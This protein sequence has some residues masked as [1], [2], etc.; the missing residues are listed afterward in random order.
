M[1]PILLSHTGSRAILHHWRPSGPW[2]AK[3]I[4]RGRDRAST[5]LRSLLSRAR[6]ELGDDRRAGLA[7]CEPLRGRWPDLGGRPL[8]AKGE[9]EACLLLAHGPV[10]S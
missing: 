5:E 10:A 9:G 3:E 7:A 2:D 6:T 4:L 8:V 1:Q